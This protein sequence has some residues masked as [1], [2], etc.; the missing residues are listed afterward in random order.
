[1]NHIERLWDFF[2]F[3]KGRSITI[4][5]VQGTGIISSASTNPSYYN[6]QYFRTGVSIKTGDM[7]EYQN[8]KWIVISQPQENIKTYRAKIRE[9][10]FTI[11]VFIGE[12]LYEFDC[13]IESE[14]AYVEDG[15]VIN[16]AGGEII[17]TVPSGEYADKIE[18][19]MRFIKLGYAWKVSGVDRS[20]KGLN[21]IHADKDVFTSDD[22][23]E[24]EVADRYKHQHHYIISASNQQP[25]G[26][27]LGKTAQ[28]V[29]IVTDNGSQ[30]ST[31]PGILCTSSNTGIAT[32]DNTGL[33]TGITNGQAT[34][35]A[36][37]AEHTEATATIPINVTGTVVT[38]YS[39]AIIFKNTAVIRVGGSAKPFTAAI[40]ENGSAITTKTVTWS[41]QN[42]TG[43]GEAM[44][45]LSD[46]TGTT[47]KL[48]AFD[49][50]TSIG[51]KVVL[52]AALTDDSTVFYNLDVSIIA[53]A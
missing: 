48:A 39:V 20:K 36:A 18:L 40:Y 25:V 12:V 23:K 37:L 45:V 4:N 38:G 9:S 31:L 19:A 28:L 16:T 6:D 35:T 2:Q 43:T 34:I 29:F 49:K 21:I 3:E 47:C 24:N 32:V 53:Y 30:V 13:I 15:K 44:T 46:I 33:V 26:V 11:K 10:N 42:K 41:V 50:T 5:G 22:D 1:M 51:Q 14:S 8:K 27:A 7:I 17:V 52:T